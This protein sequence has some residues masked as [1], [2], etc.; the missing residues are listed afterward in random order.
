MLEL[1]AEAAR[2]GAE[3]PIETAHEI[4]ASEDLHACL[5]SIS[6]AHRR[7]S[8]QALLRNWRGLPLASFGT[9]LLTASIA[10]RDRQMRESIDLVWT[11]PDSRLIPVRQTEQVLLDLIHGARSEL[12][13][14]SYAVYRIPRV[15]DGLM[16]AIDRRVRVRIVLDVADPNEIA[17]YNPLVAIGTDLVSRAD[18]LY[19]PRDRRTPDNEGKRGS[20][21]V[22]C[23]VADSERLFVSS[24]NLTDQALRLNME[25]GILVTGKGCAHQ[26]EEHFAE[27]HENGILARYG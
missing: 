23:V 16:N 22:K 26:V 7:E 24:A 14:V 13:V 18:I 3:L 21:H 9:A 19:W 11:G 25:L 20:L 10:Q 8:L 15:R 17:G 4:A 12:L 2:L 27:L 5:H 1:L 6:P